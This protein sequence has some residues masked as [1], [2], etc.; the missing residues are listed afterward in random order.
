MKTV[1]IALFVIGALQMVHSVDQSVVARQYDPIA[2][3][4]LP[5][6]RSDE[7]FIEYI[8]NIAQQTIQLAKDA[9]KVLQ[10]R[11]EQL[12]QDIYDRLFG[13]QQI[14]DDA[15]NAI[16]KDVE[17][18]N[19]NTRSSVS[20]CVE[21]HMDEIKQTITTGREDIFKCIQA[22]KA[23]TD[24]INERLF[25][26][27]E[28][29]ETLIKNVTELIDKCSSSS[30]PVSAAI[31]ITQHVTDVS[32]AVSNIIR[33]S[34]EAIRLAMVEISA[35]VINTTECVNTTTDAVRAAVEKIIMECRSEQPASA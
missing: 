34:Q 26:Y 3:Y 27:V 10:S 28:S 8:E 2:N 31:C 14:G 22:A 24:T 33:D 20:A 16:L 6:Q 12:F 13:I 19:G 21:N 1:C 25:P 11:I 7:S 4:R 30:N 15:L 18:I 23:E 9:I 32:N 5:Q 17:K 29:I 35:L